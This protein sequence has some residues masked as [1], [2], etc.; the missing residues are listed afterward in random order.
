MVYWRVHN[1]SPIPVHIAVSTAGY[2]QQYANDLP[3]HVGYWEYN[4]TDGIWHDFTAIPSNGSNQIHADQDNA[5]KITEIVTGTVASLVAVASLPVAV[6]SGGSTAVITA[7]AIV[8][9]VGVL[10][11][12]TAIGG[13]VAS[14]ILRKV[15]VGNLYAPYG[16]N[17]ELNGAKAN[18]TYDP[19]TQEFTVT[20]YDP[21]TVH[22]H[23]NTTGSDGTE[24][25]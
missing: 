24:R 4:F 14:D 19:A 22:W 3:P 13:S 15:T 2:I 25:A 21:M 1:Y 5:L 8:T 16:Y 9:A 12:I 10:G 17:F 6:L 23:N 20:S 11:A 18:G 7:G